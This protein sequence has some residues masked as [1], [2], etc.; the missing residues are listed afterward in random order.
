MQLEFLNFWLSWLP[1]R[2]APSGH[3]EVPGTTSIPPPLRR[4]MGKEKEASTTGLPSAQ[5][6]LE[7]AKAHCVRLGLHK[8]T[9]RLQVNWNPR[10]KSTA[11][12]ARLR[13]C[14]IELNPLLA[15]FE[16]EIQRTLLHE[17]AH[18]IAFER[19][20]KRRVPAHGDAWKLACKDLGIEGEKATHRLPLPRSSRQRRFF[21]ACPHCHSV[22]ARVRPLRG[23]SACAKCCKTHNRGLFDERFLL[24]KVERPRTMPTVQAAP[25]HRQGA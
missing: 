2:P 24:V 17:L 1:T 13:E 20:G 11:G 8:M 22:I 19:A 14:E 21:Y 16:E 7:M 9:T 6:L 4:A 25:S 10:L 5:S 18:L 15:S 12:L 3:N 23:R